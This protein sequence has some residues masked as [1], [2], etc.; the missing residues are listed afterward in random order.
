L[1]TKSLSKD[2]FEILYHT[3]YVLTITV[4]RLTTVVCLL[5]ERIEFISY[6]MFDRKK[7]TI[8][9]TQLF[10]SYSNICCHYHLNSDCRPGSLV[11]LLLKVTKSRLTIDGYEQQCS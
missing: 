9:H 5:F 6:E 4:H 11:C 10:Y 7:S 1:A 2:Y 8:A 3:K